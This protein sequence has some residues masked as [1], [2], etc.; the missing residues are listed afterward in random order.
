MTPE[1]LREMLRRQPFVPFRLFVS[2]GRSFDITKPHLVFPGANMVMI[3][4]VRPE[5]STEFW[6]EPAFVANRHITG[7]LPLVEAMAGG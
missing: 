7:T 2:D 1:S 3:G 6:D 4:I 5:V